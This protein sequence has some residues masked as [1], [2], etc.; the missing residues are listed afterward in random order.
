VD[1]FANTLSAGGKKATGIIY[2]RRKKDRADGGE[3]I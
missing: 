2:D 1:F 3:E